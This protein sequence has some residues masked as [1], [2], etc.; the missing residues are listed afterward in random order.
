MVKERYENLNGIRATACIGIV[1]MHVLT[2]G[3]FGLSGFVFERFIPSFTNFTLLFMLLS[4]FSMCCGY[5]E[6]FQE[7]TIS[8]EQFYKRRYQRIWPFFAV[9]CTAELILDH[10]LNSLYEWFADLTLAF[11]FIPNN[12]IDV[13]GVGWFLGTI[14]VFY[15]I[16]PF[17][18]FLI[19]NKRRA[20]SVMAVCLVLHILCIV[21][22]KGANSCEN[23]IYSSIFFVAGGLIYLC[24][25]E[26]KNMSRLKKSVLGIAT[27]ICTFFYYF[28][29]GSPLSVI[30]LLFLFAL[31]TT[32]AICFGGGTARFLFQNKVACFLGRLSME[33][34]LCHMFVY[35]F[36]EKLHLLHITGNEMIN[37]CLVSVTTIIGAVVIAFCWNR[38]QKQIQAKFMEEKRNGF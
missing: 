36:L 38:L 13:V 26:L 20:W 37:Y 2:N 11:G 1:L 14:F 4:A 10:S 29:Y 9:L 19:K 33:I 32:D 8:L 6:W 3:N 27:I 15:M 22:F 17:F 24:R 18:V 7:G 30:L 35:R 5:Y 12:K 23:I 28:M 21:R 16:F 25:K 31:F 34:Y